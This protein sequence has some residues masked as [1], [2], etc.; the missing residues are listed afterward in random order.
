[1]ISWLLL[2]ASIFFS[3]PGDELKLHAKHIKRCVPLEETFQCEE[4]PII[5]DIYTNSDFVVFV[6]NEERLE[7][8]ISEITTNEQGVLYRIVDFTGVEFFALFEQGRVSL[9]SDLNSPA[10]MTYY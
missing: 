3:N 5:V 6:V 8:R 1:M 10:F 2:S 9:L 4:R 7:Y